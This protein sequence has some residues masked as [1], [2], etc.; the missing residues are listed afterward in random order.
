MGK[1]RSK[2]KNPS[3]TAYKAEHRMLKN[4]ARKLAK[5]LKNHPADL[6]SKRAKVN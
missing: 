4:K 6:Q 2:A 1:K 3:N 5:H